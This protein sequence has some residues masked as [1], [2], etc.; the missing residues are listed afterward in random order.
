MEKWTEESGKW[1][2]RTGILEER[3]KRRVDSQ[4]GLVG[5]TKI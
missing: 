1:T 5:V 4:D 3:G 2:V